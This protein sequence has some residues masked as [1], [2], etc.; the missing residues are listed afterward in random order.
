MNQIIAISVGAVLGA[1]TRYWLGVWMD[2]IFAVG[3]PMGTLLINTTGS[4]LLGFFLVLTTERFLV[5]PEWRLL[6]AVGFFG[7]YTT[8]S[9][10]S[11]ETWQLAAD[12]SWPFALLNVLVSVGAGFLGA[13]LGAQLARTL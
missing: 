6:V 1:N 11:V 7:S 12:G 9:T 4:L 8:F 3:F 5:S 10:F 2:R 13:W